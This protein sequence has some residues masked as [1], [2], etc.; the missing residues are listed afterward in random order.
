MVVIDRT[1]VL[2]KSAVVGSAAIVPNETATVAWMGDF[3]AVGTLDVI[4][5]IILNVVIVETLIVVYRNDAVE[6]AVR[7]TVVESVQ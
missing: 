7:Y 6:T 4:S 1:L 5:G 2:G 3:V